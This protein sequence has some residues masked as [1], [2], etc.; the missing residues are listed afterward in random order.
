MGE[1]VC[2]TWFW[3][4]EVGPGLAAVG[5]IVYH[6]AGVFAWTLITLLSFLKLTVKM[7]SWC[8]DSLNR[9]K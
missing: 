7:F 3:S 4:L 8:F 5:D 6:V 9:F 1:S 2:P